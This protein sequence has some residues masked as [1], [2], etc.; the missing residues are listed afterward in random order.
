METKIQGIGVSP[1]IA[2]AP[3][4]VFN[5]SRCDVPEYSIS[6]TNA[7]LERLNRAIEQTREDLTTLYRQA[8]QALGDKHAA[9]FNVHLMLLDDVAL[10]DEV[11]DRIP[12]EKKNAESILH[13]LSLQYAKT[14]ETVADPRFR[15]RTADLLD[16]VDRLLCHLQDAK[17][18]DLKNLH[19]PSI[20]V[21]HDLSPSDTA[22]MNADFAIGLLVNAGSVTSH[23]AILARALEIPAIMGVD[24]KRAGIR[25]G[26]ILI[27]DGAK[28]Q[29]IVRPNDSTL[30]HYR[31]EQHLLQEKQIR[32][33]KALEAGPSH[34]L[35]G[36]EIETQANIEL[37][38]EI[39]HSLK[40]K[41]SGIGLYRTEYLFLNRD[42]LPEEKEQYRAYKAVTE[43]MKPRPVTLRTMDIG[44]DKFVAHLQISKEENPQLG[45]RAV[46]FCLARPD[47]FKAQLRA[48]LRASAHGNVRIM[49]PMISGLEELR[50]VK[51]VFKEVCEELDKTGIEYNQNI[52][53]G[54]MIE[55]PSAEALADVLAKECDFFSIGTNDLIQYSLAV[56]RVNEKIAY[57]YEPAHPAVIRM[58][59]Q[60]VK[61]ADI[62]G[63][64]CGICGEMAG[65]PLYTEVLLGL[66]L[67]SL[68]MS[69]IAIP[70]IRT[71]IAHMRLD[72]AKALA[73]EV[74]SLGTAGEI[75]NL[76]RERFQERG[77]VKASLKK[78][79]AETHKESAHGV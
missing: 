38:I 5:A 26:D 69:A 25:S 8:A 64:P 68:S 16:V 53:L 56:D 11:A 73:E 17:R 36:I 55:V 42:S 41:A 2:I 14:M 58:I 78:L 63:I 1:G 65:D 6:N 40:A 61:A 20:I 9:I 18:P 7:E 51:A 35:D 71:E 31:K 22:T 24:Y 39:A 29:V 54:S 19:Q 72:K 48:M 52:K 27:I 50:Q 23:T 70:L 59:D 77:A 74:L 47:I 44:G 45:W 75:K 4:L 21:A 32:L 28:N 12:K 46:R 43:A 37:P 10:R 62:A 13:K 76:L 60:V 66:G 33:E 49:F 67:T 34:T 30:A 79:R 3:A 15:E 57:L